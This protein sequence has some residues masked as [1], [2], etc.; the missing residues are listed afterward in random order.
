M[1]D[2]GDWCMAVGDWCMADVG[3]VTDV[4]L[5]L[6]TDVLLMLLAAVGD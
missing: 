2:V 6:V 3:V 4:W 1:S 5:V